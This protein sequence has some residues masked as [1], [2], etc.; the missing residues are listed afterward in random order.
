[1]VKPVNILFFVFACICLNTGLSQK[2][3]KDSIKQ[4]R[5][6]RV[7]NL[8]VDTSENAFDVSNFLN[9][10]SGFL[11]VPMVVTEPAVGHGGGLAGI[12]FYK[13]KRD[14]TISAEDYRPGPPGFTAVTGLVTGTKT[15]A[16]MAMHRG[17]AFNDRF[18]YLLAA[19]YANINID[20]YVFEMNPDLAILMNTQ[21]APVWFESVFRVGK[22]P[23]FLG[24]NYLFNFAKIDFPNKPQGT[25]LDEI[26]LLEGNYYTS[27]LGLILSVDA[28]D[29]GMSPTK[30]WFFKHRNTFNAKWLGSDRQFTSLKTSL[31]F[32][33]PLFKNRFFLGYNLTM[34]NSFGDIPFYMKPYVSMRGIPAMRFQGS[35]TITL[36]SEYRYNFYRRWS[37]VGFVGAGVP[38]DKFVDM[39]I[40]D[41]EVSGGGGFR[42]LIS[43]SY[44]LQTG[45]D[46]AGSSQGF[47]FY[48]VVGSYWRGF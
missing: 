44:G 2:E 22:S 24:I 36:D 30:G 29:N 10:K 16:A 45:M 7:R 25:L 31:Q 13:K 48:L 33:Q 23:V 1:M 4:A 46:F 11:L 6:V 9:T 43:K 26:Q 18:R 34:D 39:H 35:H 38:I 21:V 14:P 8:F 15:W 5:K 12:Y 47:A 28:R 41:V 27:G 19:G 32:Y 3:S 37:L 40:K 20:M 42:Y 17:V